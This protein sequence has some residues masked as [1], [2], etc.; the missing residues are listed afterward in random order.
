M[1]MIINLIKNQID[2][3]R[4][5]FEFHNLI[6]QDDSEV[7][8]TDGGFNEDEDSIP[9]QIKDVE[10]FADELQSQ[11]SLLR[12]SEEELVMGRYIIGKS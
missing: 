6:W 5:P 8:P 10:S 3:D 7:Y 9:F 12:L 4:D 11:L 2:D 1:R